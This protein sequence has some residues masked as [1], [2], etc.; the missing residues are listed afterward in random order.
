M[1]LPC[2]GGSVL[3]RGKESAGGSRGHKEESEFYVPLA[4]ECHRRRRAWQQVAKGYLV[5]IDIR[6]TKLPIPP[7]GPLRPL[8]HDHFIRLR[9]RVLCGNSN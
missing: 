9:L 3:L 8:K 6:I 5:R 2:Q 1:C 4:P 7:K